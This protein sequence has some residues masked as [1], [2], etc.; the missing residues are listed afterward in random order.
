MRT[1]GKIKSNSVSILEKGV[2]TIIILIFISTLALL[3]FGSLGCSTNQMEDEDPHLVQSGTVQG[4]VTDENGNAYPNTKVKV[5]KGTEERIQPTD[6]D[7]AY[8]IKTNDVGSYTLEITPPLSTQIISANPTS[9]TLAANKTS[10]ANFVLKPQPVKAH[11]NFGDVQLLEEIVDKDGNTPTDPNEPLYAAN[12][13]DEPLGLLTAI[14]A[15]DDHHVTLGEFQQ[16]KGNF[17][18]H[19]N[20]NSADIAVVLEGLIP[21]G[22]YTFWLAYLNKTRTVGEPIDFASDF[23]NFTNPP[24]GASDGSE[25]IAVAD[26]NGNIEVTLSHDSCILTDEVAL[27]IPVLY[28]INGKTFGGGHVPDPEEVVQMLAYFQ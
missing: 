8:S 14:K 23:V 10:T 12:I 3:F 5:S 2:R 6:K 18:V 4:T 25:N 9:A 27:V 20:G 19:C 16:A 13:F 1:L 7:G 26:A 21:N 17:M 22:T 28:H 24:V 11:L 15:P